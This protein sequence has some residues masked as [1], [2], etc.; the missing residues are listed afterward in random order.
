MENTKF[1]KFLERF[2]MFRNTLGRKP[3]ESVILDAMSSPFF[4]ME[5]EIED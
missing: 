4:K 2:L 1:F 5:D 3:N